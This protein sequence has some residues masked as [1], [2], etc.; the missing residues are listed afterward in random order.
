MPQ[1]RHPTIESPLR[2]TPLDRL[3]VILLLEVQ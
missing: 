2:I 1:R 3:L